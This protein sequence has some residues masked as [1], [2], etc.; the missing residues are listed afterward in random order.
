MT[1]I[2]EKENENQRLLKI[3]ADQAA[4]IQRLTDCVES[5]NAQVFKLTSIIH[6][7]VPN[8]DSSK[9]AKR[10]HNS[11]S[12]DLHTETG[13]LFTPVRHRKVR[14]RKTEFPP[15][16]TKSTNNKHSGNL[17]RSASVPS[18]ASTSQPRE[19]PLSA[20]TQSAS[21]VI[22]QVQSDPLAGCNSSSLPSSG[23][24]NT[25]A[26]SPRQVRI[27]PIVLR[28]ATKWRTL[29]YSFV[30]LSIR[31]ERAVAV[32][33]GIR[34]I[35]KTEDDYRRII[36]L[37]KEENIPHHTFP[38]PT[39][40]NIH[41][42]IRGIP[43]STTE[44]EVKVSKMPNIYKRKSLERAKWTEEQLKSAMSTVKDEELSVR[45]AGKTFGIPRKTLEKRIKQNED[46][47]KKLGPDTSFGAAHENRLLG[48]KHKF[49]NELQKAGY[50]WLQ[51]FL[52]RHPQVSVRKAESLSLARCT[53]MSRNVVI[54]YFKVLQSV[55]EEN[56][57]LKN[58]KNI[59]NMD[60]SG[61]QLNTRPGE[62]LVV[63]GS[64]VVSSVAS[65]EKGETVTV[66]ACYNAEGTFLPP[67]AIMKG[68]NLKH[69]LY[70]KMPPGSQLFLS[71]KSAYMNSD[72][73]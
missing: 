62:V 63:K 22:P 46:H 66:V 16:P 29:N 52:I 72:L 65:A 48:L 17:K 49:N 24:L 40:R 14:L 33:A 9:T 41:A 30:S 69:E 21:P 35:P 1:P 5:L 44:Q 37:F 34:I 36:R 73:S 8:V 26:Q 59:F 54:D 2:L 12:S 55:L 25:Q 31:I 13:D 64:K 50:V 39:E 68:K 23:S 71:E 7:S 56:N 67:V 11:H 53:A 58:P 27:T 20:S 45:Q 6:K 47:K 38:L 57:L 3:I 70:D 60:E 18:T 15:L 10:R 61:L 19:R 4:Q 32:D 43:A 51:S 28:D 42:V